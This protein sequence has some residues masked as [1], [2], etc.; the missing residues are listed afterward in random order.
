MYIYTLSNCICSSIYLSQF[1]DI[2]S[3]PV[4]MV[5]FAQREY[6]VDETEDG[7]LRVCIQVENATEVECLVNFPFDVRFFTIEESASN[8]D[9]MS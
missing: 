3:P 4:A 9:S 5:G 8:K 7:R 6:T 2:L 1:R